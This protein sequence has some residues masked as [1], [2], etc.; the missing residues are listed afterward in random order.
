[1]LA[2]ESSRVLVGVIS[3]E[4]L[5]TK[6]FR[7]VPPL[8]MLSLLWITIIFIVAI[9]SEKI[10]PMDY[11]TSN[12]RNRLAPPFFMGGTT[13]YLLGTDSLGRD[14]LS[15]LIHSIHT[16]LLVAFLGTII[17]AVVGTLIGFIA[18]HFK[19]WIDEV[20]MT[21]VDFQY[22]MPFMLIALLVIAMFGNN[23]VLFVLLL[24]IQGWMRFA[25]LA[26]EW[27]CLHRTTG[28]LSR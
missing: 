19:G 6:I 5:I 8:I 26:R 27:H 13:E 4:S 11:T 3:K 28:M 17:T 9:F 14:I 10:M 2:K 22:S 1:M 20:L 15:R 23:I 12:L 16:S 18:A 21:L 24:G 25:R 7:K